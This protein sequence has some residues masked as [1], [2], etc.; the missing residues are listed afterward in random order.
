MV[1]VYKINKTRGRTLNQII[2]FCAQYLIVLVVLGCA[3]AWWR[4]GMPTKKQFA[5]AVVLA[6]LIA[7]IVSRIASHIY[8]DQRPFVSEHVKPLIPH[9]RDNGFP[10]DHALLTMTLT[11]ATYFFHKK[12][13]AVMLAMTIAVGVA[14]V[15][16]KVH[17]PLD[18]AGAWI[19][20]IAAAVAGYYLSL[21]LCRR[22]YAAK[23]PAKV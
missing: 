12:I 13:A 3:L 5:V 7:F 15:L 9:G 18:I 17:S 6:A 20:A 8:F 2:I 22:T 19:I 21:W 14:R 11:A 23:H 16:A 10:S 4:V 1:I